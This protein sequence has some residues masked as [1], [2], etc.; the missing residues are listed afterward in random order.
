MGASTMLNNQLLEEISRKINEII[1]SSPAPDVEKNLRALLQ[2]MFTKLELVS[3][4]EFD[5]Q[6]EVLRNSRKKMELLEARITAL[7]TE[8]ASRQNDAAP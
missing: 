2:S 8:L 7:E 6:A 5:I 1:K 4:E 3:R